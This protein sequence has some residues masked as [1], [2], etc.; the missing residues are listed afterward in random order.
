ME[1]AS[2]SCGST[3]ERVWSAI[4]PSQVLCGLVKAGDW[5]E[6]EAERSPG[7]GSYRDQ[8]RV[9]AEVGPR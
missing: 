6:K 3:E 7:M 4:Q 5:E 8:V 2:L 9:W 1:E